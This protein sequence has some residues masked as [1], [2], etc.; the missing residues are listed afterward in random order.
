[1]F[2]EIDSSE[3][4][5]ITSKFEVKH[6]SLF[7]IY[8]VAN[9]F[10]EPGN[11]YQITEKDSTF[12]VSGKDSIGQQYLNNIKSL[13]VNRYADYFFKKSTNF[14]KRFEA[15]DTYLEKDYSKLDS[16]H[17]LKTSLQ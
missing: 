2:N 15:L 11:D 16:L 9:V 10:V 5:L 12:F 4:K 14:N 8:G 13:G 7:K 1:M 17:N 6:S 3:N